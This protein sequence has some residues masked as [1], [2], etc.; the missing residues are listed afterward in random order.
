MA[1]M[2][3]ATSV[4]FNTP[5]AMAGAGEA[6]P[7]AMVL[8]LLACA[9]V[10]SAVGEFARQIPSAGFAY[11]F[12]ARA[13]GQSGGFLSGWILTLAY[14][15]VGP[16]LAAGVGG[17]G[18]SFLERQWGL[19]V[20]YWALTTAAV[21]VVWGIAASGID[22]S[23]QT[24]LICLGVEIGVLAALFLTILIKAG[25]DGISSAPFSPASTPNGVSGLGTGMLWGILFF[26]GFESAATLGEETKDAR[27][28]IPLALFA[29]V[30]IIGTFYVFAAYTV[31]I[32]LRGRF[33]AADPEPWATLAMVHWG[34]G[35]RWLLTLTVLS[36]V[37]ATLISGCNAAV[38]VLFALGREGILPS[39]LGRLSPTRKP[40]VALSAYMAFSLLAAVVGSELI[41]P[42]G[43]WDFCGTVIGLD[44][45]LVYILLNVA[46][47][48][49]YWR[50]RPG[51][52]SRLRHGVLPV[53]SVL[54][55][56]LPVFGLVWPAPPFP[57]N[58]VPY[59]LVAW[60]VLGAGY[61]ARVSRARPEVLAASG[62]AWGDE[63]GLSGDGPPG[64]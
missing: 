17:L 51:E 40:L 7:L 59:L 15:L 25:A 48:A 20:P 35:G 53:A 36:S 19:S 60:V 26:L 29:S 34:E 46:L 47:I 56:L 63:P 14:A 11:T 10:A 16:T 4:Y 55:L 64:R 24:A 62:R 43:V 50:E 31:V 42:S 2:G 54:L 1:F 28:S 6:F 18:S 37:L 32:G 12:S 57:N 33:P 21:A 30:A 23:A 27:R 41:T 22:R 44:M 61:L 13:F 9:L 49:Y 38:R 8:A 3:P 5:L 58:L 39:A 45:V 52:F